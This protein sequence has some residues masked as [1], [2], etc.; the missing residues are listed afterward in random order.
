MPDLDF[1][2]IA[3]EI[4]SLQQ[5]ESDS[6]K[7]GDKKVDVKEQIRE[8][9]NSD[10]TFDNAEQFNIHI[11]NMRNLIEEEYKQKKIFRSVATYGAMVLVC[12]SILAVVA[13]IGYLVV[14]KDY[15]PPTSVMIGITV[16][17]V[18]NIIGLTTIVFRYVFSSTKETTDYISKLN[19]KVSV[20]E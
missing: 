12:I 16:S 8:N 20:D 7:V 18:A 3:R 17:L 10:N 19:S 2:R 11:K 14:W 1:K 9:K 13:L 4:S 15:I 6:Y 5:R